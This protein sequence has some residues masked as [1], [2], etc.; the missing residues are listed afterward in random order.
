[1]HFS[2]LNIIIFFHFG[3]LFIILIEMLSHALNDD[4]DY[5]EVNWWNV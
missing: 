4:S 1:M 2:I 3:K 5:R